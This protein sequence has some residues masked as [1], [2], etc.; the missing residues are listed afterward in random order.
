MENARLP[1]GE[2][3]EEGTPEWFRAI[4]KAHS[5]FGAPATA[6]DI[7]RIERSADSE[8]PTTEDRS[9]TP[10]TEEFAENLR[11]FLQAALYELARDNEEAAKRHIRQARE[12]V[13]AFA[14]RS[15]ATTPDRDATPY[16]ILQWFEGAGAWKQI[17]AFTD[18]ET[19]DT[20]LFALHR[21]YPSHTYVTKNDR[22]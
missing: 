17:A 2:C 3:P 22:S 1:L 11:M 10:D 6:E 18:E 16:G 21:E 20:T 8:Q 5:D 7:A 15:T 14:G 4:Q 12:L 9:T 19:R 13:E